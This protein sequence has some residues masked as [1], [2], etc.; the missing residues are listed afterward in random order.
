MI[1]NN[2]IISSFL[3][4]IFPIE[5]L[6]CGKEGVWLCNN[7]LQKIT[8]Q[9]HQKCL[10]CTEINSDGSFC[11]HCQVDYA[12]D[13]VLIASYYEGV[14]KQLIKT[15]K[16][17]FVESI[18]EILGNLLILFFG[19]YVQKQGNISTKLLPL[20]K[21]ILIPVPLAQRRHNWRGFNQAKIIAQQFGDYFDLEIKDGLHRKYRQAQAKLNRRERKQNLQDT[22]IWQG[23]ELLGK[24]I[25]LIDDVVTTGST[26]NECAKVLK[27]HRAKQVWA[28]VIA[29]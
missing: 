24:N 13:G 1:R 17:E 20:T 8:W 25:I 3:D 14:V 18:G 2:K 23:E 10:A 28:L 26:L 4:L 22:M 29:K 21:N 15:C 19:D 9:T 16:Y 11:K 27:K 12:L 5:C 7:C 6:G